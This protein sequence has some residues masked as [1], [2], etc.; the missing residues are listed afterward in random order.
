MLCLS[1]FKNEALVEQYCL[2]Y[3]NY[4]VSVECEKKDS[5]FLLSY[6]K[7]PVRLVDL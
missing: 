2:K 4:R 7:C 3:G 5:S 6:P 1:V